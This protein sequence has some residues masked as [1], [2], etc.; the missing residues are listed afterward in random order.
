MIV[1]W[2][3]RSF[4]GSDVAMHTVMVVPLTPLIPLWIDL[5]ILISLPWEGCPTFG[6]GP[7]GSHVEYVSA[8]ACVGG[9]GGQGLYTRILDKV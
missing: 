6:M 8:F 5:D 9:I 7:R 3:A 4:R 2:H 1:R